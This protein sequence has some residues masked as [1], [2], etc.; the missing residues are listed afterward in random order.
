MLWFDLVSGEGDHF[1][2][3]VCFC[4]KQFRE[5]STQRV[6]WPLAREVDLQKGG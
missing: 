2:F 4:A 1:S 5:L 3:L 6:C